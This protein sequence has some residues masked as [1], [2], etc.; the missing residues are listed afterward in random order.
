MPP[1]VAFRMGDLNKA[2]TSGHVPEGPGKMFLGGLPYNS[3]E[4][5]VLELLSVFGRVRALHIVR[6]P[7][8]P[9]H[10]GYCFCGEERGGRRR[11]VRLRLMHTTPPPP[12]TTPTRTPT[13]TQTHT[14]T[15]PIHTSTTP[16]LQ[17]SWTSP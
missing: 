12:T 4:A 5:Q 2:V 8:A 7:G 13:P 16:C 10:K 11:G 9:S 17:S 3:S 6:D 15:P 14:Y 1:P